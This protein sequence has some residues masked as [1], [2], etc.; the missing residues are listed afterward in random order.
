VLSKL[1]YE[2]KP[3]LVDRIPPIK[4]LRENNTRKGFVSQEQYR[5]LQAELPEDLRGITC[6]AYHVANRKGELFRLEWSD[7]ELDGNSPVFMLWPGETKNNDGRTLP[8]LDGE[9]LNTLR[10]LK[11]RRDQTWPKATHV[12]LNNEGAPLAHHMMRKRWEDACVRAGAPGL[13][14]HDLRRSAV[15]N[16][17]RAGVSQK[18]PES[19]VGTR[20][21]R[22][23]IDNNT[24]DFDDLKDAARRLS[25]FLGGA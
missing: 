10:A 24:T 19:L 3:Q 22:S 23:S 13:L 21:T 11:Q 15:R 12:F 16:L 20:R 1:G 4:K 6:V 5:A 2:R 7:V 18:V 25:R 9:M 8:I 14:F 17:R